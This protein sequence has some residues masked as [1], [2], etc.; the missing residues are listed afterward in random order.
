MEKEKEVNYRIEAMEKI[1][2]KMELYSRDT[3]ALY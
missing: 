2:R 1:T 3:K